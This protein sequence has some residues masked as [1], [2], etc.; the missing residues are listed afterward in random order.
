MTYQNDCTLPP[1][2]LEQIAEQGFD[3]L[4]EIIRIVIN[5]VIQA[6]RQQ[7]PQV[8]PYQYSPDRRGL[9]NCYKP[10]T[11]KSR[12]GEIK[13]DVPQI[14]EGG[15]SPG[16]LEKGQRSERA[17]TLTLAEMY[18]QCVYTRKVTAIVEQHV[19]DIPSPCT[20]IKNLNSCYAITNG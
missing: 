1:E 15:F 7:Y 10:K 11:I 16:A 6:E 4:L 5:A 2:I 14:R 13:L 17:L 19:M 9:A 20:L 8:A 18:V 12:T 3:F